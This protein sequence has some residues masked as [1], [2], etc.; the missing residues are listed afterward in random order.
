[1]QTVIDG[2]LNPDLGLV[3]K[4][5]LWLRGTSI[6]ELPEGLKVSGNLYL[7]ETKV[8][9]LPSGLSVDGNLDLEKTQI[10]ELPE[11]LK[12]GGYLD[13]QD[14]K[15]T[16]LPEGLTVD[17]SLGL[18]GTHITKFP[19]SISIGKY[20]YLKR[21][22]I[23]HNQIDYTW[24]DGNNAICLDLKNKIIYC[25]RRFNGTKDE[26][27]ATITKK[28]GKVKRDFYIAKVNQCFELI[29]ALTC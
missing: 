25:G 20:L 21:T 3:I 7:R 4:G 19:K 26:V 15:V 17:T 6:T 14:T 22:K 12:V 24:D 9:K 1:M 28:Y 23:T 8:T 29:N 10:D 27:I 11:G 13:L 16:Q 18:G 5:S 2:K